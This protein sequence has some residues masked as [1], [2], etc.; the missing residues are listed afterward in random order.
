MA[1]SLSV[2]SRKLLMLPQDALPIGADQR[3]GLLNCL[4]RVTD[5]P[6]HGQR[7]EFLSG[8]SHRQVLGWGTEKVK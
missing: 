1:A 5:G 7:V 8:Q 2:T 6:Q 4:T 3:Q